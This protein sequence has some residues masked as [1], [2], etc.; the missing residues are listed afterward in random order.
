MRKGDRIKG[1][2][3]EK[4][5]VVRRKKRKKEEKEERKEGKERRKKRRLYFGSWSNPGLC[6][7]HS[8]H[9]PLTYNCTHT[10]LLQQ[11]PQPHILSSK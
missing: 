9:P 1:E 5:G 8:T 6:H 4:R 2:G 10:L 7:P 3:G 11:L